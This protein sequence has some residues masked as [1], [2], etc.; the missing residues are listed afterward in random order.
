MANLVRASRVMM[1]STLHVDT[2]ERER[3]RPITSVSS[4]C[5]VCPDT[6]HRK[7]DANDPTRTW[8]GGCGWLQSGP[9]KRTELTLAERASRFVLD[10]RAKG[11]R[12][13]LTQLG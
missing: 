3:D 4:P 8:V 9:T 11:C 1:P 6:G 7:G 10:V 12:D 5:P 2:T 13:R